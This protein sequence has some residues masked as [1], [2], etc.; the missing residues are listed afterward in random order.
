MG[1]NHQYHQCPILMLVFRG[2]LVTKQIKIP[3][4]S[5]QIADG[6]PSVLTCTG[7]SYQQAKD[8]ALNVH[9]YAFHYLDIE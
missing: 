9:C 7:P 5:W 8:V 3:L 6:K 1:F 4:C 2:I